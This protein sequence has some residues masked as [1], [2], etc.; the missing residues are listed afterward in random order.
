MADCAP[1]L[2]RTGTV[3]LAIGMKRLLTGY[4]L[5]FNRRHKRYGHLRTITIHC[6]LADLFYIA[7]GIDQGRLD[8]LAG[9]GLILSCGGWSEIKSLRLKGQTPKMNDERIVGSQSSLIQ[10][11][12]GKTKGT[13][14]DMNSRLEAIVSIVL[15]KGV[16]TAQE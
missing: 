14:P 15:Q 2:F 13:N 9:S 7:S 1:F 6:L 11:F 12:P 8:E 4:A 10:C 16:Q 3:P 5:S